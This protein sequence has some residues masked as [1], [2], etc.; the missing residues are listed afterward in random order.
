MLAA[1]NFDRFAT[2]NGARLVLKNTRGGHY[3]LGLAQTRLRRYSTPVD[4]QKHTQ[5]DDAP[6]PVAP[7]RKNRV[8][9]RPSPRPVQSSQVGNP[10]PTHAPASDPPRAVSRVQRVT[11]QPQQVSSSSSKLSV[12]Q[13][14]QE[15]YRSAEELGILKPPP[16]NT[17]PFARIGAISHRAVQLFLFYVRGVRLIAANVRT[18]RDLRK[19]VRSGGAPLTRPEWLLVHTS[20]DDVKRVVPFVLVACILEEALP[21]I[22]LYFPGF[23]PSTCTLPSQKQRMAE[24]RAERQ[25]LALHNNREALAAM[26]QQ[27]AGVS[28]HSL[29][30]RGLSALCGLFDLSS[31]FAPS[32]LLRSRLNSRLAFVTEDDGYLANELA[33]SRSLAHLTP[34]E[35]RDALLQRGLLTTN[36]STSDLQRRLEH[37]VAKTTDPSADVNTGLRIVVGQ[38]ISS[39][40]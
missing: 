17:G 26:A 40:A 20:K 3:A 36:L 16:E 12:W 18:A 23:L 39:S 24:Q 33:Q 4:P 1:R 8:E 37:W 38:A 35:L 5:K 9:L 32:F 15:D 34:E 25:Q 21:F 29:D 10:S 13:T 22:V 14:M 11:P 6:P 7:T 19:R 2:Q 30:A 31:R 28:L 27:P